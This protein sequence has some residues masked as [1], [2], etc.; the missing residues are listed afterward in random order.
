[1]GGII[2][3]DA[4][5]LGDGI[6]A[7]NLVIQTNNDGT[8]KLSRGNIGGALTDILNIDAAGGLSVSSLPAFQCRAW[9]NYDA[10][11][12]SSGA[13]SSA[14]TARLIRAS[15][16]VSSV[17]R[18]AAGDHTINFTT[19]MPDANYATFITTTAT[20][21]QGQSASVNS[22]SAPSASSVRVV[23]QNSNNSAVADLL[24]NNVSVFR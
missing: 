19:P 1:M 16:N 2:K 6:A 11:R 17:M 3:A 4:I 8:F 5:Q 15:G 7:N 10:T 24:Y 9:V 22:A 20:T 18:N 23:T 13:I 21:S 14:N 12:D